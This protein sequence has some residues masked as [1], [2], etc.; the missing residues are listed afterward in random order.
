[1]HEAVY[2]TKWRSG[3]LF[4]ANCTD[5]CDNFEITSTNLGIAT[6]FMNE[7]Y[8]K[9]IAQG[10][11]DPDFQKLFFDEQC[12]SDRPWK[13]DREAIRPDV[14]FDIGIPDQYIFKTTKGVAHLLDSIVN[15]AL[16]L[17]KIESPEDINVDGYYFLA[18]SIPDEATKS[19]F[20]LSDRLHS[21]MSETASSGRLIDVI[22]YALS[23]VYLIGLYVFVFRRIRSQ[24]EDSAAHNRSVIFMIPESIAKKNGDV[25]AYINQIYGGSCNM[26]LISCRM[27]LMRRG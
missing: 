26:K 7:E 1:L 16:S 3:D 25:M 4:D 15:T 6:N 5:F 8:Q 13:C 14:D 2:E 10:D 22:L 11:S 17:G 23:L 24:I 27:R 9:V 12:L 20:S 21:K 19:L 18:A